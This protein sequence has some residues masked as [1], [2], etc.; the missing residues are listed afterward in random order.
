MKASYRWTV[1]LAI[2]L[3][4]AIGASLLFSRQAPAQAPAKSATPAKA[5]NAAPAAKGDVERGRYLVE[6][7]GMCEECHTPR[8]ANG[9]L[10]ESRRLEGAAIWITPV[11]PMTNWAMRAPALAGFTGFTDEQGRY[12]REG[13]RSQRARHPATDAHL[14]HGSGRRPGSDRL[15]ALPAQH[16]PPAAVEL[17][18]SLCEGF[19]S[20][21]C[22]FRL[23]AAQCL[24]RED[25]SPPS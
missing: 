6:D 17:S 20:R 4:S 19:A 25:S 12:P 14:P 11:H 7:V 23:E 2:L 9:N 22:A 10:D 18:N 24:R 3:A 16:V 21:V 8:D 5:T 1:C 15:P 13:H